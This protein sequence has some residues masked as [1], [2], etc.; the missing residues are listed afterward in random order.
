M[1]DEDAMGGD[2]RC[3]TGTQDAVQLRENR[4]RLLYVLENLCA[5]N[6][7]EALGVEWKL[8]RRRHLIDVRAGD[9]IH[10]NVLFGIIRHQRQIGLGAAADI[11]NAS[12][13]PTGQK[14]SDLGLQLLCKRCQ[15]EKIGSR[16]RR[17]STLRTRPGAEL[18]RKA[19]TYGSPLHP[20]GNDIPPPQKVKALAAKSEVKA[21]ALVFPRGAVCRA[22]VCRCGGG[23]RMS[24]YETAPTSRMKRLAHRVSAW[25]RGRKWCLFQEA[26]PNAFVGG[27]VLDIGYS[28]REHSPVN[29]F[30]EKHF[31]HPERLTA[32]GVEPHDE[33]SARYPE[34]AAVRYDGGRFPFEDGE[35]DVVWSNAVVEHVGDASAQTAFL[36]EVRRVGRTAFVTTPNRHFPL[37]VHTRTPFLHYL[38]KGAFD[39]YLRATGRAW[40]AGAYMRLLGASEL[41]RMLAEAGLADGEYSLH[42]NRIGPFTLDFVVIMH[43]HE[44]GGAHREEN[45]AR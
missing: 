36:R 23:Q 45:R 4:G 24:A 13:T 22:E 27:R 15:H 9:G 11:E 25:N 29:N 41:R 31:P 19:P 6:K 5:E 40:A 14:P 16:S 10:S 26:A 34:V 7:I 28:N 3:A 30:I 17:I 20:G 44:A 37:D 35:F 18:R 2:Q 21:K 12:V 8:L 42:R 1:I 32:L 33:F 39:R 38:P 43:A